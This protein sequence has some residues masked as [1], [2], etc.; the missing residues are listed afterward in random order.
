[1]AVGDAQVFPGLLTPVLTQLPFQSHRLL[2]SHASAEVKGENTPERKF[3]STGSRTRNHQVVSPK[4]SPASQPWLDDMLL[5]ITNHRD[6]ISTN[7]IELLLKHLLKV[8]KN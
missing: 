4:S 3:A 1:M 7:I 6:D 8:Q 5:G 2:L